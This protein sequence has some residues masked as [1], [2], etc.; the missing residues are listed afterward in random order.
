MTILVTGATGAFGRFFSRWLHDHQAGPLVLT[1]RTPPKDYECLACDMTDPSAVYDLIRRVAPRLVYHL[2]GS[3]SNQFEIDH[4]VNTLA[5]RNLLEASLRGG[6]EARIVLIGSAA[7][8]GVTLPAENP[9][10]EDRVLRPV[11]IY[12]ITK[13]AQTHFATYYAHQH[14]VDV[15]V[16]RMFNLFMTGLSDRLFIGRVEKMIQ[17][18]KAGEVETIDVGSLDTQRDYVSAETAAEQ[19]VAIASRGRAGDI[20]HVGSGR[21]VAIREILQTMLAVAGVPFL[22]VRE[23]AAIR[24]GYDASVV[25]ADMSRT[26]ALGSSAA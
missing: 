19:I 5:A 26:R 9:L 15:V 21:A 14:K 6:L 13:A 12:G 7:E 22:A 25:Y 10:S 8:Y 11:S 16:A 20:Y 2:A 1:S 24:P 23:A 17:R 18:Y 3:Y 4:A